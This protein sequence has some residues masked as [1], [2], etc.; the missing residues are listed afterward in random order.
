MADPSGP[1]N[2]VLVDSF[3]AD[4]S[5]GFFNKR[6]A[7]E[8]G[9]NAAVYLAAL[10]SKRKYFSQR[11]QLT[12]E[13][14]FFNNQED[15]NYAT[16]L[17]NHRQSECIAIL[18]FKG[19]I[20][21]KK[22]GLPARNFFVIHDEAIIRSL[23]LEPSASIAVIGHHDHLSTEG[24]SE[25][26]SDTDSDRTSRSLVNGRADHF[27][28]NKNNTNPASKEAEGFRDETRLDPELPSTPKT[29]IRLNRRTPIQQ[30]R[31]GGVYNADPSIRLTPPVLEVLE[32]WHDAGLYEPGQETKTFRDGVKKIKGLLR[33]TLFKQKYTTDDIRVSIENFRLAALSDEYLPPAGRQ[34]EIFRRLPIGQFIFAQFSKNGNR[35]QFQKYH[36]SPPS[37]CDKFN[38]TIEDLAPTFTAAL[39]EIYEREVLGDIRPDYSRKEENQFRQTAERFI[40]FKKANREK[41]RGIIDD[42]EGAKAV[43][44]AVSKDKRGDVKDLTPGW[45]C[46]DETWNR[47]FPSYLN[48]QGYLL[49]AGGSGFDMYRWVSEEDKNRRAKKAGEDDE[50]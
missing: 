48:S 37:R 28:N 2:Q 24:G 6:T 22:K 44:E 26:G 46:S 25:P 21:V 41:I 35:S 5:F 42:L 1:S 4:D 33:G 7:R 34:K 49:D 39:K 43:F 17:D 18:C 45:F 8:V 36:Q 30:V 16:T 14:E 23:F 9:I 29:F 27:N 12:E 15:M 19:F 38:G 3:F 13:G 11:N 50:D 32:Y 20:S 40:S 10:V 31:Y 47:R